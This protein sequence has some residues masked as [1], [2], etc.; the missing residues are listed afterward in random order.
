MLIDAETRGTLLVQI[1]MK[2]GLGEGV[3]WLPTFLPQA[4]PAY[5]SSK[6][7][8]LEFRISMDAI[9]MFCMQQFCFDT[10][11]CIHLMPHMFT[12]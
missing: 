3:Y 8:K 10:D 1:S 7:F 11:I 4:Y 2:I 5:A 9:L 6:I 12:R